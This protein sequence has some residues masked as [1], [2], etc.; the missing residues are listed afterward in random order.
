[1]AYDCT[2][3]VNEHVRKVRYWMGNFIRNLQARSEHHDKSKLQEPEKSMFDVFTPRLKEIDFGSDEYKQA[4]SDMGAALAHHY[5]HNRH[6]PEHFDNGVN[7]MTLADL[8]EMLCDWMAAAEAKHTAIDLDYLV[9]RFKI[10]DQLLSIIKNT[11]RE[12][13]FWNTVNGVPVVYFSK[14]GP[15]E[16]V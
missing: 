10:D 12:E 5:E 13:D 8:L 1:M 2:N 4:L 16:I 14:D 9:S 6:H 11:L 3:D 15:K 7:G